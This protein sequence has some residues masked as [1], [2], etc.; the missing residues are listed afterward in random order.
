MFVCVC[1]PLNGCGT[2][3]KKNGKN[4]FVFIQSYIVLTVSGDI[5]GMVKKRKACTGW[6]TGGEKFTAP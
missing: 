3:Q 6:L 4:D 5:R 2:K 1:R